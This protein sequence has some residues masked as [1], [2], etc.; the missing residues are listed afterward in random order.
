MQQH[1]EILLLTTKVHVC[2][3]QTDFKQDTTLIHRMSVTVSS[4]LLL[5]LLLLLLLLSNF[6][7]V[8]IIKIAK[9]IIVI[10]RRIISVES[11]CRDCVSSAHGV[12]RSRIALRAYAGRY[13]IVEPIAE[14]IKFVLIRVL[15]TKVESKVEQ[16]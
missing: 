2:L 1:T 15:G 11:T 12:S 16:R 14:G 5:S 3:P 10:N 13:N 4:A 9:I 6:L 7:S 8:I